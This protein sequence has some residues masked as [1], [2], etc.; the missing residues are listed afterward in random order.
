MRTC[1]I[2][3][4][5]AVLITLGLWSAQG[6]QPP[7]RESEGTKTNLIQQG[8]YLVHKVA[9]C[10]DCHTPQDKTGNPDGA[11][12]LQG[13]P[14]PVEP[15]TKTEKWADMAPDISRGGL[16]GKWSEEQMVKFLM[17]GHNPDGE[18]ANPPMP[19]YRL[20]EDDARAVTAYLRSLTGKKGEKPRR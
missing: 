5:V 1:H 16:A 19:P 8:T 10:V 14:V 2:C 9:M 7:A 4:G 18:L 6:G 13:A 15:K 12:Q 17:T 3:I 20:R 11:R